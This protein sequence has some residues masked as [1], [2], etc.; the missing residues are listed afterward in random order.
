MPPGGGRRQGEVLADAC[1]AVRG[2]DQV[3]RRGDF[4]GDDKF[5]IGLHDHLDTGVAG[6]SSQPIFGIGNDHPHH[7]HL[8]LTQHLQGRPAEMAGADEGDPHDIFFRQM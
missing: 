5:R 8:V 1:M 2:N 4:T 6:R 7:I 3:G